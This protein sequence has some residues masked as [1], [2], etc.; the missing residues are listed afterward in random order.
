MTQQKESNSSNNNDNNSNKNNNRMKVIQ[1]YRIN[2]HFFRNLYLLL[3]VRL[4]V[5]LVFNLINAENIFY[6]K[7]TIFLYMFRALCAHD[8]EVKIVLYSI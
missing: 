3:T 1:I 6:N 5:I 2:I 7:F 8:R 4:S